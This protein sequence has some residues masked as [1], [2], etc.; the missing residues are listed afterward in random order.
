MLRHAAILISDA[1]PVIKPSALYVV[2]TPIGNLADITLRAIDTLREVQLIAAEDTRVTR[3]LLDHHGIPALRLVAV[4]EHNEMRSSSAII[5][6]LAAGHAVALVTDA[7]TPAISDPGARLVRA[8]RE[9]GYDVFPIP[10]PNAAIAA[11]SASGLMLDRFTFCGFLP[12]KRGERIRVLDAL[13]RNPGGLIFYEAPHR[14]SDSL[15]DMAQSLGPARQVV[16]ARELTKLFE[17]IH[18]CPLGE[19]ASWLGGDENRVRGEFVLI[20]DAAPPDA[21]DAAEADRVLSILLDALPVGQAAALASKITG[22]RKND[23]YDRALAL[24]SD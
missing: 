18:V 19:A 4:H 3:R 10:G 20:V 21:P 8:V 11:L 1:P 15:T 23:L 13:A 22:A 24:K 14:V 5:E 9:A 17:S 2:A 7:G 6:A 16:I 12:A